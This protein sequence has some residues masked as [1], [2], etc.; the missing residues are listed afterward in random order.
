MSFGAAPL[1]GLTV[2]AKHR[3]PEPPEQKP[4]P[5]DRGRRRGLSG[6][7]T[8]CEIVSTS[9]LGAA[10]LM[11]LVLNAGHPEKRAVAANLEPPAV[12]QPVSQEGTVVAVS[13]DSV[14]MRGADG[15]VQTYG[16]TPNTT[17]VNH[18][19]RQP[20][21]AAPRFTVND[22]VVV[23]GTIEGG[24]ALATAVAYRGA[25][26]GEAPPMDYGDG[27]ALPSGAA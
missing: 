21:T 23:V 4:T 1:E 14:T 22:K 18:G 7:A 25:G 3:M 17:V 24:K 11:A 8:M 5:T 2:S 12:S 6:A 15:H 10:C 19:N 16:F 27:Q 9:L 13:A 26:H 20:I